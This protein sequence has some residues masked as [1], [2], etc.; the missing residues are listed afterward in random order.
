MVDM[1]KDK[2][3]MRN[4]VDFQR[5]TGIS[6]AFMTRA[7]YSQLAEDGVSFRCYPDPEQLKRAIGKSTGRY[8]H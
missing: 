1:M 7:Q 3:V 6:V 8:A 5:M 4:P 2:K